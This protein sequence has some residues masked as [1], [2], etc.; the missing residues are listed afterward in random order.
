MTNDN[1]RD[2]PV[3]APYETPRVEETASFETLA[4]SCVKVGPAG[5]FCGETD[6]PAQNS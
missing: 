5:G 2:E 4:L 3:R 6:D 1:D